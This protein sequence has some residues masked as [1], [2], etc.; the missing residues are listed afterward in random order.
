[1]KANAYRINPLNDM[2]YGMLKDALLESKLQNVHIK[3][4]SI[5]IVIT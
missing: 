5:K 1:M 3:T 4:I 2:E